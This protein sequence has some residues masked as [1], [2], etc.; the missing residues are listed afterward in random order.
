VDRAILIGHR[1]RPPLANDGSVKIVYTNRLQQL[2]LSDHRGASQ[3]ERWLRYQKINADYQVEYVAESS[4]F[5][6][7]PSGDPYDDG[8]PDLD[9]QLKAD[10]GLIRYN[11]YYDGTDGQPAKYLKSQWLSEGIAGTRK[12]QL[13]LEYLE[14]GEVFP[15][16]RRT[17][18]RDEAATPTEPIETTYAYTFYPYSPSTNLIQQVETTLP[19]VSTAENGPNA[20][21]TSRAYFDLFGRKIWAQDPRGA[22]DYFAYDPTTGALLQQV[23]DYDGSDP[24]PPWSRGGDLPTALNLVT[25]Y[26]IDDVGRTIRTLGPPHALGTDVIR[27]VQWN[28]YLDDQRE[29]RSANGYIVVAGPNYDTT[30]LVNP[31]SL[32]KYDYD[33]HTTD[34]IQAVASV[35]NAPPE[36]TDTYA[37]S[38]WTRWT[39]TQID[40]DGRV[41]SQRVYHTI[42]SAGSGS[43]GTNYDETTFGYDVMGQRNRVLA[44]GG[45]ITRTVF[46]PLDRTLS[47]WIGT[48]D[49]D[50]TDDDPTG[51]GAIGNNMRQ[52]S[53]ASYFDNNDV[54]VPAETRQLVDGTSGHDRVVTNVIDY[55]N[56]VTDV[57]APEHSFEQ[58]IYDNLDR[59]TESTNYVDD[60]EGA[61]VASSFT[62]FDAQGRVYKTEQC[63]YETTSPYDPTAKLTSLTWFDAAGNALKQ[64]AAGAKDL[65]AFTKNSYDGAGRTTATY[66]GIGPHP[67][68]YEDVSSVA[69]DLIFEQSEPVYDEAGQILETT[70]YRRYPSD[71]ATTGPLDTGLARRSRSAAW[72]D[73]IGRSIASVNY[74]TAGTSRPGE[75][76]ASSDEAPVMLMSYDD[77]GNPF[78]TT[79]PLGRIARN[80]Y[81]QAGRLTESI[82]NYTGSSPGSDTDVTVR[83]TYDADG[84][85][86]TLVA[87]NS[88]TGDQTTTYFYGVTTGGGS[89]VD[90]NDL[91]REV[92][93]PDS[94]SGTD[95]VQYAYNRLGEAIQMTD[96]NETV[97]AYDYD[98]LGRGTADRVTLSLGSAIDDAVLRL[99]TAYDERQRIASVTSYD[100]ATSGSIVNQ[101]VYERNG[102]GQTVKEYQSHA[103]AVNVMTT[104]FVGY[105]YEDGSANTT[106]Q[107]KLVYPDGREL[108]Y[109]FGASDTPSDLLSRTASLIDDD[110]TSVLA[111][112]DYLGVGSIVRCDYAEP[113]VRWDLSPVGDDFDGLD[114]LD[115]IIDNLWYDY[116]S[117]ADAD[118]IQYTYDANG[119]R[120]SR[121]N[122]VAGSGNDELYTYDPVD[123]LIDMQRGD[124]NV[125]RDAITSLDFAQEWTLDA[126]GNWNGFKQDD[127]GTGG[128]DLT[129]TRS[130]NEVNEITGISGGS[131]V[132]PVYDAAGNMTT[133]PQ[134]KTPTSGYDATYDAWNRL[135]KLVDGMTD[136]ATCAYDPLTRRIIV[137]DGS[138]VRHA[139]FTA[140]W[141]N[142]EERIDSSTDAERQFVW[143]LRYTD[144]LVLRDRTV[145]TPL[146]ERLY[147]LQDINWNVDAV[148]D[149]SGDVQERYRYSAYGT[150]TFL[151]AGFTP[152]SPDESALEWETL[153]TGYRYDTF[154][155]I[156]YVRYRGYS[157]I[158]GFLTRDPLQYQG[159]MSQYEYVSSSPLSYVDSFG[160]VKCAVENLL[161]NGTDGEVPLTME[162]IEK[163][164]PGPTSYIIGFKVPFN[165]TAT[166]KDDGENCCECCS[167]RQWV[168]GAFSYDEKQTD[169][170]I[171][172]LDYAHE[173]DF[174][175][176][177]SRDIANEDAYAVHTGDITMGTLKKVKVIKYGHRSEKPIVAPGANTGT[178][179]DT[180]KRDT[181]RSSL[182]QGHQTGCNYLHLDAPQ[183]VQKVPYASAI[184][185]SVGLGR[186][187]NLTFTVYVIDTCA[188][189]NINK[190]IGGKVVLKKEFKI[191]KSISIKK[192]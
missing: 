79:D 19:L 141:R 11:D 96:Q 157:P 116:G 86:E 77:A 123:R 165:V 126:T 167:V 42:P 104:P 174:P 4:A 106:R 10:E 160:L 188:G 152:L 57:T 190:E 62:Y 107:T 65:R 163:I 7:P 51:G 177:L 121:K 27:T 181:G 43:S 66:V 45:T 53:A 142:I 130:A 102:F 33:G 169:G 145:S 158:T 31:V 115:R 183:V 114:G 41:G 55:R 72:Y 12:K 82:A 34:Q 124:L 128:W 191:D 24:L 75:P 36:P 132:V 173:L 68:D 90:S 134:P 100:A 26:D 35:T 59:V 32:T 29:R 164:Y 21:V 111:A 85:V 78:E 83:R 93:Y 178:Y 147:A 15:V 63:G 71:V 61:P 146:D 144:D 13:E 120:L 110:G 49:T 172:K 80:N 58:R 175:T 99:E 48:D 6:M 16:V 67:E 108:N 166:F 154:T 22:L 30:T 8:E 140:S 187:Q 95:R 171:K 25:D 125:D 148:V 189:E 161:I 131:W 137:D 179:N 133:L 39:T 60:I 162:P 84:H 176:L 153:Y 182:P 5:D 136:V 89:E 170:T 186:Y 184:A 70:S 2:L 98:A 117:S 119:N 156:F 28:L 1:D 122:V 54:G 138:V 113:D 150:P 81:D 139:Y 101:V 3:A 20:A 94:S 135:V 97:H 87:L 73:G 149:P 88:D 143:G 103:G 44:P 155:G 192:A 69:A 109:D 105:E 91:L 18:Y 185:N 52:V 151:D 129:Q 46:D 23:R 159:G 92:A 38:T 14:G 127:D 9:V 118:R 40:D 180:V 17:V 168:M 76:P 50:A 37:Q 56:R 47:T 74:G 64:V 112:Y